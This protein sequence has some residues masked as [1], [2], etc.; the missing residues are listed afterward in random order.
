MK[1]SDLRPGN[2]IVL[3]GRLYVVTKAEHVKPGKGPA[4]AALKIRDIETGANTDKRFGSTETVE[5]ATLDRRTMEYLYSDAAGHTFMD[6]ETFDQIILHNDFIGDA[7][8]YL[9]P[10][11]QATILF[12]N[13]R[14]VQVELPGSVELTVTD[15]PP[16][17]KGATVTNQPK[18]A[19]LETGLKTRV[20]AFIEPGETIRVSTTTGEYQSRA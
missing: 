17:I 18:E 16:G 19:T 6:A 15:T 8:L 3:D 12:H 13:G 1:A 9:R 4:Y 11:T 20:P 7:M 14:P 5:A 2:A 10:N